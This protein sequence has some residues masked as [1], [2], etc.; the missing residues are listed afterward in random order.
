[1][2][3]DGSFRKLVADEPAEVFAR[4]QAAVREGLEAVAKV[5]AATEGV[6][7][8]KAYDALLQAAPPDL[9]RLVLG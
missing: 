5:K 6:S 4:R 8:E 1:M 2:A 3:I 7:F 9:A